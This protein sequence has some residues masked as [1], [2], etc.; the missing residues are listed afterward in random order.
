MS[1]KVPV[2]CPDEPGLFKCDIL[3]TDRS[4]C[5]TEA[6]IYGIQDFGEVVKLIRPE[7]EEAVTT[8][9]VVAASSAPGTSPPGT[10]NLAVPTPAIT[11]SST[12]ASL[13]TSSSTASPT[14][15]VITSRNS[16]AMGIGIG[17]GL[18]VAALVLL[19]SFFVWLLLKHQRQ[20][21]DNE[22][23]PKTHDINDISAA[24]PV[25]ELDSRPYSELSS[26]SVRAE[27]PENYRSITSELEAPTSPSK[28]E[29][30]NTGSCETK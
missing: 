19:A 7:D 12:L 10:S 15:V 2:E 30:E 6:Q 22:E 20:Q 5:V 11:E 1:D 4:I 13:I 21:Q 24:E 14:N 28:P 9:F 17:V 3:Y 25:G 16:K 23:Q 29:D 27:L 18:G 26:T 8:A